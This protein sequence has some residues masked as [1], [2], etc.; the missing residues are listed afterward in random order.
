MIKLNKVNKSEPYLLF[1]KFYDEALLK[2]QKSIQAI[3][4]S[5][6]NTSTNQVES[7]FVNLK[8][9]NDDR[10]IFFSNYNSQKA[11]DFLTHRQISAVFYWDSLNVQIRIKATIEK[12]SEEFS[13][14]HYKSRSKEKN[15]LAI[16]SNQSEII[17]SY[18]KVVA[19]FKTISENAEILSKRPNFWGGYSFTPFYFEFWEGHELRLNK[20]DVYQVKEN[21]WEHLILQP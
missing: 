8:Y 16:S 1:K 17:E 7:R 15:A 11:Q 6:F 14:N 12:T 10:W 5:S 13:D 18:S 2:S 19:K 9:I 3:C 4:I 20:R 21:N